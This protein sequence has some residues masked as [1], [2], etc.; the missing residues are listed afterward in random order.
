MNFPRQRKGCRAS[1]YGAYYGSPS[2]S[3]ERRNTV[4]YSY[5]SV[6]VPREPRAIHT[7]PSPGAAL[8]DSTPWIQIKRAS[9]V[10]VSLWLLIGIVP[11]EDVILTYANPACNLVLQYSTVFRHSCATQDWPM[12]IGHFA[13]RNVTYP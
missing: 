4:Q 8:F 7:S 5:V 1:S 9:L 3:W 13:V 12:A 11:E 6:K 10:D 2:G